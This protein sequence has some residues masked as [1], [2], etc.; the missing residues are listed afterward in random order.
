MSTA[1]LLPD[2]S[3]LQQRAAV[4]LIAGAV[5]LHTGLLFRAADGET[6]V[7]HL[8]MHLR[9]ESGTCEKWV[10][11]DPGLDAIELDSVAGFCTL[12]NARRPRLPYGFR[13]G[14]S[15]LDES[16]RFV[17]GANET[18]L[19]CATFV[20]AVFEWAKVPL[21]DVSTWE[22]RTDDQEAQRELVE[23][24]ARSRDATKE[25]IAAV[26]REVGCIRVRA[27]EVAASSTMS[28]RPVSFT[29]AAQIGKEVLAE[30]S[31][32]GL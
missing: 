5:G 12:L 21:I 28:V 29:D 1:K 23:V 3:T 10:C 22:V 25:H 8:A 26:K 31:A 4:A 15:R 19:T 7:L 20:V 16:G 9:L 30:F 14:E 11:A 18:G 6:R 27:E 24:L 13:L 2:I 17:A 32:L